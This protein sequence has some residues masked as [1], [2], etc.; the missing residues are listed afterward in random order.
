MAKHFQDVEEKLKQANSIDAQNTV[1]S[2][3]EAIRKFY[4]VTPHQHNTPGIPLVGNQHSLLILLTRPGATA[5]PN[6]IKER[7]EYFEY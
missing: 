7:F 2:E 6:N 3:I 1:G 5:P 4:I